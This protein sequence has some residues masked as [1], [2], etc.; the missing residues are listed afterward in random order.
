M[1]KRESVPGCVTELA[2]TVGDNILPGS[3][4]EP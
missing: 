1:G 4:E 3:S 2:T